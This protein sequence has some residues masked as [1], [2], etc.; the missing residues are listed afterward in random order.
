MLQH[1]ACLPLSSSTPFSPS[2][3]EGVE[4]RDQTQ[5]TLETVYTETVPESSELREA[6]WSR[7][8]QLFP[9]DTSGREDSCWWR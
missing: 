9:F 6:D 5:Q 8:P 7:E 2:D 1:P 3:E 4:G